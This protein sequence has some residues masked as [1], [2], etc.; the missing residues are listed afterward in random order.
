VIL[1]PAR[2]GTLY[3]TEKVEQIIRIKGHSR[4]LHSL[5]HAKLWL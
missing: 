3:R 5:H 2:E 1:V 4:S